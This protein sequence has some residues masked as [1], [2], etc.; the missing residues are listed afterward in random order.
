MN[1]TIFAV[2]YDPEKTLEG[3]FPKTIILGETHIHEIT[4]EELM[5]NSITEEIQNGQ[6]TIMVHYTNGQD[7][8]IFDIYHIY[9]KLK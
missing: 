3:V 7:D 9:R 4:R 2:Q 6:R 1:K 5:V 8:E